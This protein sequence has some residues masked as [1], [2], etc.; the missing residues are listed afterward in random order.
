MGGLWRKIPYTY[1]VMVIGTLALTGF[2]L[3]AGYFSKDAIIESVKKT[4]RCVCVEEGFPQSGVGAEI[5]ARLMVDAFDYLD[6]PVA[7][8]SGVS[9]TTASGSPS[10]GIAGGA[11]TL[12]AS[13]LAA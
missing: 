5:V 9:A 11:G 3:T 10:N 2:P 7:R 1:A 12:T 6:A 8:V 13:V 4:G